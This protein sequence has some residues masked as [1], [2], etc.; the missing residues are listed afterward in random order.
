MSDFEKFY[1]DSKNSSLSV[2]RGYRKFVGYQAPS[3][4]EERQLNVTQMDVFSRLMMER[5][6]YFASEVT[7]ETCSIVIAQLLYLASNSDEPISIYID[8]PGGSCSSGYGLVETMGYITPKI[9]TINVGV[10][11]SMGSLILMAGTKGMRRS[12]PGS[13]VLLHQPRVLGGIS[14]TSDEIMIEANELEKTKKELFNFIALRTGKTYEEIE[15]N[16]RL[17]QWLTAKEALDYGCIDD[18]I[19]IDWSKK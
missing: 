16:A 11:A 4:L 7:S 15:N 13:K 9:E 8:S 5:K 10:A 1:K 3:I 12:L 2:L 6:I 17:D 19:K 14:G 18:I